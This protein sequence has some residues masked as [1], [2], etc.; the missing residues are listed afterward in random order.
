MLSLAGSAVLFHS[1]ARLASKAY[2]YLHSP[3]CRDYGEGYVLALVQLLDER[4]T[5]FMN[6]GHYPFVP[7]H[8]P[9]V[10]IALVWPF[11]HFFGPSL[12]VPRLLSLLATVALLPVLFALAVALGVSRRTAFALAGLATCPWFLQTWAPL[13]R[14]DMLALLF[15]FAGLLAFARGARLHV[16]FPLFWLAFFTK[17]SALLAP[18]AVLLHILASR[19][20][21]RF[22]LAAAGFVL[23]L[24]ALFA[25]LTIATHG[26][27]FKDMVLYMAASGYEFGKL[28]KSYFRFLGIAWPLLAV[29][30]AALLRHRRAFGSG[31]PRLMLIYWV[32]SILSLATI[33]KF[34]AMQN[35]FIEPWLATVALTAAAIAILVARGGVPAWMRGAGLLAAA[36][37]A[38]YTRNASHHL[39]PAISDPENA[40]AFRRLWQVVRDTDGPILSENL[41]VL[42]V[43]RKPVL[44]EPSYVVVLNR[45][46]LWR[47]RRIVRDCEDRVFSLV[48][49]EGLLEEV[50]RLRDCFRRDYSEWLVLPPY[51][52]LRPRP[53]GPAP[54]SSSDRAVIPP[55]TRAVSRLDGTGGLAS[56]QELSTSGLDRA[57]PRC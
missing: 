20:L 36:A 12:F 8:Y 18:A 13:G 42:V 28:G 25:S 16:V 10:F 55:R 57:L 26:E 9:P 27:A 32:L 49:T 24:L 45:A 23:P 56:P 15:S 17:Q 39:P 5:Y 19:E 54:A 2:Q 33:A 46:D 43:N 41:A 38:L 44:V 30:T 22:A 34:G 37:A 21:R 14:I 3:Y 4:G 29:I 7:G 48:V 31:L 52:L 11:Y 50:P 40:V 1:L 47:P 53:G 35:Y 51:R 6:M